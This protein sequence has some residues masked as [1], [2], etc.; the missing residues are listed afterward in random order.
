MSRVEAV[1]TRDHQGPPGTVER[2][3]VPLPKIKRYQKTKWI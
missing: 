1:D 2:T 3:A